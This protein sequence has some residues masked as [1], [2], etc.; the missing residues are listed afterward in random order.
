VIS[1]LEMSG[2]G[3][4]IL[5]RDIVVGEVDWREGSMVSGH[6]DRFFINTTYFS[7][8]QENKGKVRT[9]KKQ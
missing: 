7:D 6:H 4:L 1:R 9:K 3:S 2:R 5:N 8:G